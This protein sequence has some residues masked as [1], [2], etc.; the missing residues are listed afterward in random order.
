MQ[1]MW[2]SR[3]EDDEYFYGKEPNQ[4]LKSIIDETDPGKILFVGEG[5]GRNAV[6]AASKGWE[7]TAIDYS[8]SGK[9]KTLQFAEE[10]N[11]SLNYIV[12]DLL[13]FIPGEEYDAVA[14]SFLHLPEELRKDVHKKLIDS[15]V[16]G[17]KIFF[18]VFDEDQ[19][20]F[21]S[22]GPKNK[23]H[24]YTLADIV[25]DFQDLDFK[26]LTKT[27]SV[28]SEGKGHKGEAC[29]IRFCGEKE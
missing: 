22:G 4:F 16:T 11:V 17:G 26:I 3:F 2:N 20:K 12:E 19:L 18:E 28:L 23:D 15:L 8:E 24:L 14:F 21:N 5:E 13:E 25:E 10:A 6:Y 27:I 29:L 7:V 9:K 1:E